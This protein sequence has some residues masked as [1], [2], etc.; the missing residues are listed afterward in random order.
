[1]A[2]GS[3]K[4]NMYFFQDL[5]ELGVNL[6][7]PVLC[8]NQLCSFGKETATDFN[9]GVIFAVAGLQKRL[10]NTIF[11]RSVK[12]CDTKNTRFAAHIMDLMGQLTEL[13]F[14]FF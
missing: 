13:L 1:M 14:D 5:R 2:F 3:A 11:V 8:L 9:D 4:Q 6:L 10:Q 7:V 12:G